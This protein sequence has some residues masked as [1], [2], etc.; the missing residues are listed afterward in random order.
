M[1]LHPSEFIQAVYLEPHQMSC[2]ELG[3]KLGLP[4]HLWI[5]F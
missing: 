1:T 2:R 4:P 5:A 3:S